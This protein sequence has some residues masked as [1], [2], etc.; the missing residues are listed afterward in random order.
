MVIPMQ[1]VQDTFLLTGFLE[2]VT[3]CSLFL[4]GL[5]FS[6]GAHMLTVN[7]SKWL[8]GILSLKFNNG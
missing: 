4:P 6:G 8:Q 7:K 5:G 3:F 1:I 2:A